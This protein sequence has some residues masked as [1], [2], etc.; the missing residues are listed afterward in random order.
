MAAESPS[1][2]A[3]LRSGARLAGAVLRPSALR[4]RAELL[5]DLAAD[6]RFRESSPIPFLPPALLT[7][8]HAHEV[9]LPPR[10]WFSAGT[11]SV[12]GLVFLAALGRALDAG[13]VFEIGTHRGLTAWCL[14]RN[15]PAATVHTLDLPPDERPALPLEP[16]DLP[17]RRVPARVFDATRAPGR[18]VPE[19]GDSARFDFS[20]WRG[21]C[22]LVYIDGAHSAPYVE[23]DTRNALAMLSPRGAIVWDDYWRAVEG[24]RTVLDARADLVRHRVPETRLVVHLSRGARS[25]LG[26]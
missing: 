1:R 18:I 5:R 6:L 20:P 11:Q 2:G 22:D 9:V 15:L 21:A 24:V 26:V 10:A 13:T 23:S 3:R 14:A 19:H 16:G 8:I 25:A 17:N 7:A 4:M 12:D